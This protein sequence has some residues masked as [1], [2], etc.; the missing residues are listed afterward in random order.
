MNLPRKKRDE[1]SATITQ[2]LW[3]ISACSA[4]C[5][6][7]ALGSPP[8]WW[9][10]RGAVVAPEVTT[11]DGVVTT[12]YVPNDYAAVTQGQL[13]QFTARAVDE[14]N[15]NLTGGA[16]TNLNG[17]VSN[18]A[19]DYA[20]NG[21]G[22]TN[23]KPSDYTAMNVGQLKYI[24]NEVWARLVAGGYTSSAPTWLALN[25]NSDNEAANLG[26]LKEIFNF[27]FSSLSAP[28]GVVVSFSGTGAT[29]SW[30]D[31]GSGILNFIIQSS[32]D[33]GTTWSTLTSVSGS[34][35]STSVSGLTLGGDYQFR[36]SASNGGG[37]SPPSS[38]DAAP[39]IALT[40]P[41]GATLVP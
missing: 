14:L 37:S 29:I 3:L 41:S 7:T 15:A 12:N 39:L 22:A 26:Q 25:T 13:K 32:T 19:A 28:T 1:T 9:S 6:V 24:G 21:Y 4:L 18:W 11:N 5:A 27:E 35:F 34:T 38:S 40:T 36:V 2:T 10:T 20:T 33:G 16:G 17:I 31:S 8:A 23:I 30:S